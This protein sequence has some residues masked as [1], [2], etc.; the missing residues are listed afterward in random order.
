M[1]RRKKIAPYQIFWAFLG[2]LFV[3]MLYA[4]YCNVRAVV[5]EDARGTRRAPIKVQALGRGRSFPLGTKGFM[6]ATRANILT[7]KEGGLETR[8]V[9]SLMREQSVLSIPQEKPY[10]D[11]S[12][13]KEKSYYS[14]DNSRTP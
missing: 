4:V 7:I 3:V 11:V 14:E 1:A 10:V 2:V 5:E 6:D 12:E 8:P 13:R 9:P